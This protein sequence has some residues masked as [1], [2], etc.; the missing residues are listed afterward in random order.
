MS[1]GASCA[2][3]AVKRGGSMIRTER[4]VGRLS[5]TGRFPRFA[6][7]LAAA[8][9]VLGVAV[10]TAVPAGAVLNGASDGNGH[11][12]VGETFDGNEYCSGSL[13]SA[14]VFVTAAHCSPPSTSKFA[15]DPA[16]GGQRMAL[17]FDPVGFL[18]D[19]TDYLKTT[20]TVWGDYYS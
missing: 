19:P 3:A 6:A 20:K 10:A 8:A 1:C 11:P 15:T 17:T 18:N 2:V 4:V 7:C 13:I 14:Q 16:T 9:T 12:Y 5:G